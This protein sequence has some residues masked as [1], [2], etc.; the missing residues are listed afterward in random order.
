MVSNKVTQKEKKKL[1]KQLVNRLDIMASW[2]TRKESRVCVGCG[3]ELPFNKRQCGHFIRRECWK[4]RWDPKNLNTECAVCNGFSPDHLIGYS[5]YMM[6]T[7]QFN[8]YYTIYMQYVSK[9]VPNE[10]NPEEA[11]SWYRYWYDR[12]V[13]EECP[14]IKRGWDDLTKF[15]KGL[16]SES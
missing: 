9:E 2:C 15:K 8:K 5:R 12:C 10:F 11:I 1:K 6:R 3:K 13:R 14:E 7:R 16:L 4:T